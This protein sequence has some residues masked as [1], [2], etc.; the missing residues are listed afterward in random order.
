M[1]ISINTDIVDITALKRLKYVLTFIQNHPLFLEGT[2]LE[3]NPTIKSDIQIF[4]GTG[5]QAKAYHIPASKHFFFQSGQIS[6]YLAI[7]E[8][9][10]REKN[11]P[12][13][14]LPDRK[15]PNSDAHSL[16]F[17]IFENIFFHI[18][19]YEEYFSPHNDPHYGW[20]TEEKHL[21]IREKKQQIPVVD[22]YIRLLS[23]FISSKW[24]HKASTYSISHDIDVLYR[25]RPKKKIILSLAA[26]ILKGRSVMQIKRDLKHFAGM[27]G[28][29]KK[30]PYDT[31]D[32]LFRTEKLW[33]DKIV[34]WIAGG[35][36]KYERKYRI[37]HPDTKVLIEK[38][39]ETGYEMGLHPSFYATLE[40]EAFQ[41]EKT[42]L[43]KVTNQEITHNRNHL[44]RYF[45]DRSPRMLEDNHF[46]SDAS[47]GYNR[48]LGF[49]AGT[50]F[51]YH[52]YDFQN[53]KA[54]SFQENPFA[55]MDSAAIHTSRKNGT[56]IVALIME[57]LQSTSENSHVSI[58][59][60]NS[61]M[62]PTTEY[63]QALEEFYRKTL[64]T[65]IQ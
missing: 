14:K 51:P 31:F 39:R 19:R 52:L 61:N 48:H 59:F 11:Y 25:F 9:L 7:R 50:G 54:F 2:Q 58:N 15:Q 35:R 12:V 27:L 55:L 43:E 23:H 42:Q 37:D 13:L 33:Q 38:A 17:D 49:R 44:L 32:F 20:L 29:H 1:L 36:S 28:G 53:E 40:E 45:W 5:S 47:I 63:G 56:D 24:S 30:D 10:Y 62:D 21:L 4:Y 22:E 34:Y 65:I 18:S 60:H 64:L 46:L 8:I 57:F 26:S 16:P 6:Q 3:L 41:K